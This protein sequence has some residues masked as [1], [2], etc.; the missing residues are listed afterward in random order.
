VP[1]L[2]R[3]E[4]VDLYDNRAMVES[5]AIRALR[6]IP[7]EALEAHRSILGDE[8]FA[9]HDILFHRA[10]VAAQPSPRLRR[11]HELL[12]GEVEL[13]IGQVQAAQLLAAAEIAAQHQ[14]ILDAITSGDSD[15]AAALTRSHIE[16]SRDVLLT[17]VDRTT[18][19]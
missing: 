3:D 11:M 10:L 6:S 5:A 18:N 12:M 13:C 2:S 19:G 8:D 1:E 14:G 15:R 4:I 17:H 16:H 9:R 7:A